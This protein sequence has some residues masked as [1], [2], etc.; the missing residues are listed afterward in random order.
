MYAATYSNGNSRL[1]GMCSWSYWNNIVIE[2]FH[3]RD[4]A[5]EKQRHPVKSVMHDTRLCDASVI[6]HRSNPPRPSQTIIRLRVDGSHLATVTG[7]RLALGP[8]LPL[9]PALARHS[10]FL[11]RH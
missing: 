6:A 1:C 3:E 9:S 11:L 2:L 5:H 8:V 7:L 10:H 4:R